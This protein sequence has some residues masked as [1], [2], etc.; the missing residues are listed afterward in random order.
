MICVFSYICPVVAM[1]WKHGLLEEPFERGRREV[2]G[3]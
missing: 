2:Y 3:R 1:G